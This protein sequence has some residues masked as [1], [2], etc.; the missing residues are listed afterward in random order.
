MVKRSVSEMVA[1]DMAFH[2][3]IYVLSC[4]PLIAPAMEVHWAN[5]QRVIGEV[6]LHENKPDDVWSQHEGLMEA[7]S[8]GHAK[9]AEKLAREH[10]LDT[11]AFMIARLRKQNAG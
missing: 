7:V 5:T 3:F 11:A 4:N 10:I 6:L 9:L 2:S 8:A 1:A